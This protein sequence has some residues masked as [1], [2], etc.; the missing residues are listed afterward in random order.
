M[1]INAPRPVA[2]SVRDAPPI[3]IQMIQTL[4]LPPADGL[5]DFINRADEMLRGSALT[6]NLFGD[7]SLV[8]S[9]SAAHLILVVDAAIE[10]YYCVPLFVYLVGQR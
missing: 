1:Q 2:R 8:I 3:P 6:S 4:N 9:P 5:S 7:P 10:I